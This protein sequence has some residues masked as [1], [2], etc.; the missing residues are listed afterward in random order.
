MGWETKN[1]F[2]RI[3]S[4][5]TTSWKSGITQKWG[6]FTISTHRSTPNIFVSN[7]KDAQY[8]PHDRIRHNNSLAIMKC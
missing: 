8:W 1:E 2:E 5:T 6:I 3:G 7:N 4:K